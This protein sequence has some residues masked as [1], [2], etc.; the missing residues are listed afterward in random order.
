MLVELGNDKLTGIVY[1]DVYSQIQFENVE[2]TQGNS[3]LFLSA[4]AL[5]F[6]KFSPY[7]E[8]ELY[9][10]KIS[11]YDIYYKLLQEGNL[12]KV[13]DITALSALIT[14]NAKIEGEFAS[15][16]II[17]YFGA[18]KE[19]VKKIIGLLATDKGEI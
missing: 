11:A 8:K 3:D 12:R 17:E 4:Y 15:D 7:E 14:I 19:E 16:D 5:A 13:S 9:K 18:Q 1:G 10:L 6:G 2:F